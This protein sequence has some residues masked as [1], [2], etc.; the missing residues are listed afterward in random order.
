M[1]NGGN[2]VRGL[3]ETARRQGEQPAAGRVGWSQ[4]VARA[5]TL[6]VPETLTMDRVGR[7]FTGIVEPKGNALVSEMVD[8]NGPLAG[9]ETARGK[10]KPGALAMQFSDDDRPTLFAPNDAPDELPQE[11]TE[12]QRLLRQQEF[13]NR[14]WCG[15]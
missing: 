5:L 12:A 9:R 2:R 10:R 1:D 13:R 11:P 3:D 15:A 8:E 7:F 14:R 4:G 6:V